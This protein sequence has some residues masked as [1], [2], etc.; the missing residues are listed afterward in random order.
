MSEFVANALRDAN[1]FDAYNQR[2]AYQRNDY[3][4]WINRAVRQKTKEK[5][6]NQMLAELTSGDSYMGMK[7][8]R[9]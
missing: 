7:W 5:R 3:L 4:S 6:L 1:L 2:P 8:R 9:K